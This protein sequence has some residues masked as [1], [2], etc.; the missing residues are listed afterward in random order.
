LLYLASSFPYGKNDT[1]FGPEFGELLRQGVDARAIPVRPRGPVTTPEAEPFAIR[2]PL[3]DAGI[4][5]SALAETAR[6]PLA[7]AKAFG[8]LFRKPA[9][10][11]LVRN[12][13]AFPKALWVARYARRTHADHIHAPWAGPPATVAMIASRLSGV[14]WSFTGHFADIAANNL[15]REKCESAAFVRFIAEAM[16]QL[17]RETEPRASES[18]WVLFHS[19]IDVPQSWSVADGLNR[20]PVLL[21]SARFDPEKRHE[22]LV[23]A[24][25]VLRDEGRE[26][27][28]WLA[29][30]GQLED[31]VAQ[32]VRDLRLDG[33]VRMLGYVPNERV[34]GWLETHRVDLVVLPSDAEGIPF[35]L[36]EALAYGVPAIACAAG[37]V[38][39]LLGDGCGE[40]VEPGDASGLAAA[41]GR[42]LDSPAQRQQQARRGRERVE[43]EFSAESAARRI[44]ELA[45]LEAAATAR[46][47]QPLVVD[48]G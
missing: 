2:R 11:V 24:T 19:G 29:G 5:S 9:P 48:P 41:I 23:R 47:D 39:E 27:E 13:A 37:G 22:T 1:F 44:Q 15:L 42:L 17:A 35:S 21:M 46:D 25:R 14:P 4:V 20:P 7:V 36:I 6:S 8:A 30:S 31:A 45:G 38:Q 16:V 28:V 34:R 26:L 12:L 10:N 18:R 40:L 3:L 32:Q 43:L 33:V